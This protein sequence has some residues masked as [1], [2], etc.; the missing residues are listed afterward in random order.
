MPESRPIAPDLLSVVQEYL[1]QEISPQVS[2]V[3]KFQLKIVSRVLA[4]VRR[5]LQQGP[6]ADAAEVSRLRALLGREGSVSELNVALA[7]AIREGDFRVDDPQL[8]A[9]LRQTVEA[10]LAINNPSWLPG[11]R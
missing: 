7:R 11:P 6:A 4:T 10:S 3:H 5:E 9:H 2:K 8:L 1:E